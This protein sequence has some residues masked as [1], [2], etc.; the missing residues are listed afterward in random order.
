MY[1]TDTPDKATL[2]TWVN[3][4]LGNVLSL[5]ESCPLRGGFIICFLYMRLLFYRSIIYGQSMTIS[6]AGALIRSI[7]YIVQTMSIKRYIHIHIYS[8]HLQ[9]YT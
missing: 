3:S 4:V 5:C 1:P 2:R 8:L 9:M 6:D 7:L